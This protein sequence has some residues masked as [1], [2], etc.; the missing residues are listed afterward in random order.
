MTLKHVPSAADKI[1][2]DC[3][4][5]IKHVG[6]ATDRVCKQENREHAKTAISF[7]AAAWISIRQAL[8]RDSPQK[9]RNGL[10]FLEF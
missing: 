8:D 7:F 2:H 1:V 9:T 5:I 10:K 4:H 6:E 3:F